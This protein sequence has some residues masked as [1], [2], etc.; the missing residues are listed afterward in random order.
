MSKCKKYKLLARQNIAIFMSIVFFWTN[1][2]FA[3]PAIDF[4]QNRAPSII[5]KIEI[6]LCV[7][8]IKDMY[9]SQPENEAKFSYPISIVH[10]EDA[11]GSV[12][13]QKNQEQILRHLEKEYGIKTIFVEGGV[14][15]QKKELLRFFNEEDA[16]LKLID[17]LTEKG[18]VGGVERFLFS[19]KSGAEVFGVENREL[20]LEELKLFREVYSHKKEASKILLK[21][22]QSLKQEVAKNTNP[23]FKNFFR[24]W[25]FQSEIQ[26][27]FISRLGFLKKTA[28][29]ILNIDLSNAREQHDFPQLVRFFKL[30]ELEKQTEG[31]RE[32][33]KKEQ[34]KL[35]T[36]LAENNFSEDY[37]AAFK[38]FLEEEKDIRS[39]LEKFLNETQDLGFEFQDYPALVKLLG[40]R[41]LG[42]EI[43][44]E[45]LLRETKRINEIILTALSKTHDEQRIVA[46]YKKY[47][48]LKSLLELELTHEEYQEARGVLAENDLPYA[49]RLALKFYEVA[50]KR[51]DV[52]FEQMFAKIKDL[53]IQSAILITGGFHTAGL[54]N[55]FKNKNLSYVRILPRI[56]SKTNN[57]NYIK[58][59]TLGATN[60]NGKTD[61][62]LHDDEFKLD[63]AIE[64][65]LFVSTQRALTSPDKE[66]GTQESNLLDSSMLKN[67]ARNDNLSD[68]FVRFSPVLSGTE[69]FDAD[70][71]EFIRSEVREAMSGVKGTADNANEWVTDA[72]PEDLIRHI[73]LGRTLGEGLAN[74]IFSDLPP[75]KRRAFVEDII[76]IDKNSPMADLLA[77]ARQ[78]FQDAAIDFYPTA[79]IEGEIFPLEFIEA[80]IDG[81]LGLIF[82]RHGNVIYYRDSNDAADMVREIKNRFSQFIFVSLEYPEFFESTERGVLT[83][84]ATTHAALSIIQE[85]MPQVKDLPMVD[86]GSDDGKL[87]LVFKDAPKVLFVEKDESKR[88]IIECNL[89]SN[90]W[91]N[92]KY[93]VI[94]SL[95]A[96]LEDDINPKDWKDAFV[97][98]NVAYDYGGGYLET[99]KKLQPAMVLTTGHEYFSHLGYE[100]IFGSL[101]AKD[102]QKEMLATSY[103]PQ[104][105]ASGGHFFE[106]PNQG[107]YR[108]VLFVR[109]DVAQKYLE[110][111][112]RPRS[113][114]R[115]TVED[116]IAATSMYMAKDFPE[117]KTA[118]VETLKELADILGADFLCEILG[119]DTALFFKM[120]ESISVDNFS[121]GLL[122]FDALRELTKH[123]VLGLETV[124]ESI[125]TSRDVFLK[126]LFSFSHETSRKKPRF[127]YLDNTEVLDADTIQAA[128]IKAP[129]EVKNFLY[130]LSFSKTMGKVIEVLGFDI[131]K[132]FKQ[133]PFDVAEFLLFID[134][135]IGFDLFSK[136]WEILKILVG[137]EIL[138]RSSETNLNGALRQTISQITEFLLFFKGD[139]KK[140]IEILRDERSLAKRLNKTS[141]TILFQVYEAASMNAIRGFLN[142]ANID[143]RKAVLLADREVSIKMLK[144]NFPDFRVREFIR[145]KLNPAN[146]IVAAFH[147]GERVISILPSMFI[148]YDPYKYALPQKI[149]AEERK[150][151]REKM[152]VLPN[153]KIII[154]SSPKN[155]ELKKTIKAYSEYP[156][157]ERPLLIVGMRNTK[158][159]LVND[160]LKGDMGK[161]ELGRNKIR[162]RSE[163]DMLPGGSFNGTAEEVPMGDADIVILNTQGELRSFFAVADLAIVG[164]NRNLFEPMSQEVPTLF[165]DGNWTNNRSAI[166][167]LGAFN[168]VQVV[169]ERDFFNQINS[170][171]NHSEQIQENIRQAVDDF[172]NVEFPLM[173]IAAKATILLALR[174]TDDSML[175]S[176]VR[177]ETRASELNNNIFEI[178]SNHDGA[179][180]QIHYGVQNGIISKGL[181]MLLFDYHSDNSPKLINGI[182]LS[183]W[184]TSLLKEGD[185][186]EAFWFYPSEGRS[187][188][189]DEKDFAAMTSDWKSV[190]AKHSEGLKQGVIVSIDMDFFARD[191]QWTTDVVNLPSKGNI[192][193]QIKGIFE[194]LREQN[195]P[196]KLINGSYSTPIYAPARYKDEFRDAL[197]KYFKNIQRDDG[198]SEML[199]ISPFE[200]IDEAKHEIRQARKSVE[201]SNYSERNIFGSK[202]LVQSTRQ[203]LFEEVLRED[204]ENPMNDFLNLAREKF[205]NVAADFY[206]P[207]QDNMKIIPLEFIE[208]DLEGRRVVLFR[209][210]GDIVYYREQRETRA[211]AENLHGK[212]P[213]MKFISLESPGFGVSDYAVKEVLGREKDEGIEETDREGDVIETPIASTHIALSLIQKIA[214]LTNNF[215]VVDF[216]ADDGKL[217]LAFNNPK[218]VL[219][220]EPGARK[221]KSLVA[222]LKNNGL[223]ASQFQIVKYLGEGIDSGEVNPEEWKNPI[224][225]MNI[226]YDYGLSFLE[227]IM[228]LKP[229]MILTTGIS[230]FAFVLDEFYDK[231]GDE[232]AVAAK[233]DGFDI[234]KPFGGKYSA[235]LFVRSDIWNKYFNGE[236]GDVSRS[237]ERINNGNDLQTEIEQLWLDSL[238]EGQFVAD[239]IKDSMKNIFEKF[240]RSSEAVNTIARLGARNSLGRTALIEALRNNPPREFSNSFEA[241]LKEPS[242]ADAVDSL[243]YAGFDMKQIRDWF[244]AYPIEVAKVLG[245][246]MRKDVDFKNIKRHGF[247]I[248]KRLDEENIKITFDIPEVAAINSTRGFIKATGLS[249]KQV[250]LTYGGEVNER[251]IKESFLGYD[252][253][254]KSAARKK[255]EIA[256]SFS[257]APFFGKSHDE[258]LIL[259]HDPYK[260]VLPQKISDEK[261]EEIRKIMGVSADRII[262]VASSPNNVEIEKIFQAYA[263]FPKEQ[264]PLL[265]MGVRHGGKM[266]EEFLL[267]TAGKYGLSDSKIKFRRIGDR[268]KSKRFNGLAEG[269]PMGNADIIGLETAGELLPILGVARLVIVGENHNLL[270]PTSQSV[271]SIHMGKN[272]D[273]NK[274]AVQL[275]NKFHAT[276]PERED[277][278]DQINDIFSKSEIMRNRAEEAVSEFNETVIPMMSFLGNM[279]MASALQDFVELS[280]SES[281]GGTQVGKEVTVVFAKG[282]FRQS[283]V[284][285]MSSNGWQKFYSEVVTGAWVDKERDAV[286][287]DIT[288]EILNKSE[289]DVLKISIA[290]DEKPSLNDS[291]MRIMEQLLADKPGI[292]IQILIPNISK[293]EAR[294]LERNFVRQVMAVRKSQQN[295]G[296]GVKVSVTDDV[297]A[298]SGFIKGEIIRTLVY[299]AR[300]DARPNLEKLAST[301]LRNE[302]LIVADDL[303]I[304]MRSYAFLAAI[305]KLITSKELPKTVQ[306]ASELLFT[307]LQISALALGAISKSA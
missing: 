231:L 118:D 167:I 57:D 278:F 202:G 235:L 81:R 269:E 114:T 272:W 11:H 30:Q 254:S 228:R 262:I 295:K 117:I 149:S 142:A 178:T 169:N 129:L 9:I 53:N 76:K 163:K 7:G 214:S 212:Y 221:R 33:I 48:L 237:E 125:K 60:R 197:E 180:N 93:K 273:S 176:T 39:F 190:I 207:A 100:D 297:N 260:Y 101:F 13:A 77:R 1:V 17:K 164:E 35:I 18:I 41:L 161:I 139:K 223:E 144:D 203:K 179:Y 283:E 307:N 204:T 120:V 42:Q 134:G 61:L 291:L 31:T 306:S 274:T 156:E 211:I 38:N 44:A 299:D 95:W 253:R 143:A 153:R 72:S 25:I 127:T 216:G 241:S 198:R 171:L 68:S 74:K 47:L 80:T 90:S 251:L 102:A 59:M 200:N 6:P 122:V 121:Y 50:I 263:K 133:N 140:V 209:R 64:Q 168:A 201:N 154:L 259:P 86:F 45:E 284:D 32:T 255:N 250:I 34:T 268:A 51:D 137:E 36:W 91:D 99:I 286:A 71:A 67:N 87:G 23:N 175:T 43:R 123:K 193:K 188:L 265:I 287:E 27:D 104:I 229:A 252:I 111:A 49:V 58:T 54:E 210:H 226:A 232:S 247:Q 65:R 132:I 82:R 194:F 131:Q 227:E 294:E 261:H 26:K 280:R 150:I 107:N 92:S 159:T 165:F 151:L 96:S 70:T 220:V 83:P 160:I 195:I 289:T 52:M 78:K 224:V 119:A 189:G 124:R 8:S 298:L 282:V 79:N 146:E 97:V 182:D 3:A 162:V 173:K 185:V 21:L 192:E 257:N 256:I 98:M 112:Q 205:E 249:E 46:Q 199:D 166:N 217:G 152:E 37:Q 219:Y 170:T 141:K 109:K 187:L 230:D 155:E 128:F 196:V 136:A 130:S 40:A 244:A 208:G 271:P 266:V 115:K 103:Q 138:N 55:I 275:L 264:K 89:K 63:A 85:V 191:G 22:K 73:M 126:A 300:R 281:R 267:K 12:E 177:S 148:P 292:E 238:E 239:Y 157:N 225:V 234:A 135:D 233:I 206:P 110:K 215:S 158:A 2:A 94:E 288:R 113:E 174:E 222:N 62:P 10:I 293:V 88:K 184:V 245:L 258:R 301:L 116:L 5:S 276:E 183:N 236:R 15:K 16:N 24:E 246:A 66:I 296:K 4:S 28:L 279:M 69:G 106:I 304:D 270:E 172:K 186:G 105:I 75:A 218:K 240:L 248:I 213:H 29:D 14:G 181:P 290:M 20:Y 302:T 19:D 242:F 303:S 277:L 108:A 243:H 285:A 84:P 56:T 305:D 145:G 147:D